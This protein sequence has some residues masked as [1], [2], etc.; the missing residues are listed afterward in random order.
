MQ[1][2]EHQVR[3]KAVLCVLEGLSTDV[4]LGM[5]LLK[6]YNPSISWID[7]VVGIPCL[8][9]NGGV[10]QSSLNSKGNCMDGTG[11]AWMIT[12]S[13]GMLYQEK[14]LVLAM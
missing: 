14:V 4:I 12:Y 10:C 5:D 2:S 6:Q 9:E 8:V 7:S 3:T 11:H 13:N 1:D